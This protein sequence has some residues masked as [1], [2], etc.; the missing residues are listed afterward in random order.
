MTV[1][2]RYEIPLSSSF[3]RIKVSHP[4][5]LYMYGKD[6]FFLIFWV[7]YSK[8]DVFLKPH[9]KTYREVTILLL[10]KKTCI[11]SFCLLQVM[12]CIFIL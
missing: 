12:L 8:N 9:G 1:Q 7:R 11:F 6:L 4:F 10:L 3:F 5:Y 2:G